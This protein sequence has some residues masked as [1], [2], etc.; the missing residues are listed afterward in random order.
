MAHIGPQC[1]SGVGYVFVQELQTLDFLT[2]GYRPTKICATLSMH[3][4]IIP[5]KLP[6]ITR[7]VTSDE[8]RIKITSSDQCTEIS[9][10]MCICLFQEA[11]WRNYTPPKHW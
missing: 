1:H 11:I 6:V 10:S 9:V 7:L 5:L 2:Y 8:K 3:K 4:D